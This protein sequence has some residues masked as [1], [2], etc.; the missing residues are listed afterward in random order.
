M[1][2]RTQCGACVPS[3]VL[4]A[5]VECHPGDPVHAY[6]AEM[7]FHKAGNRKD[8]AAKDRQV[9][10]W[11]HASYEAQHRR[12]VRQD[13]VLLD[14]GWDRVPL[15]ARPR[16]MQRVR[17][18]PGPVRVASVCGLYRSGKSS[19]LNWLA[20]HEGV[21]HADFR[22]G[23]KV[24]ACTIGIWLAP[25]PVPMPGGAPPVLLMDVEGSGSLGM[26][27]HPPRFWARLFLLA[28][29]L[30]SVVLFNRFSGQGIDKPFLQV[31]CQWLPVKPFAVGSTRARV[32]P[33]CARWIGK[34]GAGGTNGTRCNPVHQRWGSANPTPAGAPA[35]AAD[36]TQRPDATC[37]G[38]NG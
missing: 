37:E 18:L 31:P 32:S 30:S 4:P 5:R 1:N 19:L 15:I 36:R 10:V 11:V 6:L 13:G 33:A 22:V 29:A 14:E 21:Q 23:H 2:A 12:D 25:G 38:K 28:S 27:Q 34:G 20:E 8:L 24:D 26:N 16:T 9:E 17:E 35:A 3:Q 7:G